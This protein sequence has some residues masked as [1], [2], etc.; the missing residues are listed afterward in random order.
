MN[1]SK[2]ALAYR[3]SELIVAVKKFYSEGP[4]HLILFVANLLPVLFLRGHF[5]IENYSCEKAPS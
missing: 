1:D 4:G 2:N 3:I 5:K